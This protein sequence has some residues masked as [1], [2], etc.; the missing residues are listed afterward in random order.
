MRVELGLLLGGGFFVAADLLGPGR[1]VGA[2]AIDG[3]EL[4]LE[5]LADLRLRIAATGSRRL[6]GLRRADLRGRAHAR[7][8]ED[9]GCDAEHATLL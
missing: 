1:I 9:R 7:S 6:R 5:P 8:G 4:L 2:A 3:G